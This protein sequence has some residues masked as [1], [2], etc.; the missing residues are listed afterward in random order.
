MGDCP[1]EVVIAPVPGVP[2]EQDT[3][4]RLDGLPAGALD[5][6][7]V[8]PLYAQLGALVRA[9]ILD[10]SW[11][12]GSLLPSEAEFQ[13]RFGVSRSVVRQSL[14]GLASE[15]LIQR[16]RGRGSV[17]AP[18]R[19]HHRLV[20]R[21]PGLSA[22]ISSQGARVA[23][24]VLSLRRGQSTRAE[25]VLGTPE[26]LEIRRVRSAGDEPIALIHTW[27]RLSQD[28]AL[29]EAELTDASLHAILR[30]R[31]DISIV[32][33]SRQIR[34]V[35][36]TDE[37]A[38]ALRIPVDAPVLLLEGTSLDEHGLAVEL[39]ST[40]HR[41]DRVVFDIDVLREDEAVQSFWRTS[42]TTRDRFNELADIQP[43]RDLV[44]DDSPC[45]PQTSTL[46]EHSSLAEHA[47]LL[48]RQLEEFSRN[49]DD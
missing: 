4:M 31:F 21:I 32:S 12:P 47:R 7:A 16:G 18:P 46:P 6:E 20:Q 27:L 22:Q 49:L 36:A 39:F 26:V 40:W 1:E 35:S 3:D 14:A 48:A 33:G 8:T 42:S 15:G 25:S 2:G 13:R 19:E 28:A 45:L 24:K 29:T 23:T 44:G 30:K 43:G 10:R 34:A 9:R 38:A 17:V 41:G 37:V 5:Q 11:P